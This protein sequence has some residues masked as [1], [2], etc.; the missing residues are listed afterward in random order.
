MQETQA[1]AVSVPWGRVP[2]G[3]HG[4]PHQYFCLGENPMDRGAWWVTVH[5]VEKSQTR[6][7]LS[8]HMW[9]KGLIFEHY[10][11]IVVTSSNTY[12]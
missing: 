5:G 10:L 11:R 9:V 8:M 4:N 6:Q 2:G 1:N 7:R 12:I 3:G